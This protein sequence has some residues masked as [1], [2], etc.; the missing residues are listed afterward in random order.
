[1]YN[2]T[3]KDDTDRSHNTPVPYL[4]MHSSEH[5]CMDEYVWDEITDPFPNFLV[6]ERI[7]VFIPHITMGVIIDPHGDLSLTMRVK[8]TP[9]RNK[10]W[11]Y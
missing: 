5:K 1:M 8:G 3:C 2:I 4:I 7:S 11:C 6:W 10:Q 9:G